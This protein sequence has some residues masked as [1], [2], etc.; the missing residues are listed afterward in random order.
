M[1]GAVAFRY[2]KGLSTSFLTSYIYHKARK[3]TVSGILLTSQLTGS[4]ASVVTKDRDI[5]TLCYISFTTNRGICIYTY[6]MQTMLSM[7]HF[8]KLVAG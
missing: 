1:R 6:H 2:E 5:V 7:L 3:K 8:A 4:G